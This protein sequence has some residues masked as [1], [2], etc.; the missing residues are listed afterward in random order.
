MNSAISFAETVI[1]VGQQ[2][3]SILYVCVVDF[4]VLLSNIGRKRNTLN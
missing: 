3:K 1:L 4:G 2:E